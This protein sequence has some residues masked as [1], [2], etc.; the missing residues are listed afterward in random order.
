M[1]RS[2]L[3]LAAGL[4]LITPDLGGAIRD[5]APPERLLCPVAI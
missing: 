1:A 3:L 5:G 2:S 4:S